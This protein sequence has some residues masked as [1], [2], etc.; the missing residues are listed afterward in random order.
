[1][2]TAIL[3]VFQSL[4]TFNMDTGSQVDLMDEMTFKKL[5]NKPSLSSCNTVLFGYN[6]N[7]PIKVLGEFKVRVKYKDQFIAIK[8][9]VTKRSS[10][11]LLS[12]DTS[13]KLGILKRVDLVNETSFDMVQ[14]KWKNKY[15]EL[16]EDRVGLFKK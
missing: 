12:Y 4:V 8:L 3:L 7:I 16:F 15:P 13:V 2:P 14:L 5:R 9:I 1:M 11:S 10:G 6:S